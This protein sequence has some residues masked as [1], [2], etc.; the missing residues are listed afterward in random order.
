MIPEQQA[1]EDG[2]WAFTHGTDGKLN[3]FETDTECYR[4]WR[5]G[6]LDAWQEAGRS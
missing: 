3:P 5:C 1:Y 2:R 4:A 6:W